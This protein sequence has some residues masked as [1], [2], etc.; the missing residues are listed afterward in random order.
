MTTTELFIIIGISSF[1]FIAVLICLA[2]QGVSDE[3][4]QEKVESTWIYKRMYVGDIYKGIIQIH[5]ESIDNFSDM[6][7]NIRFE[8]LKEEDYE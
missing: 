4:I 5:K 1:I 2:K 6:G 8:D 3:D 7:C